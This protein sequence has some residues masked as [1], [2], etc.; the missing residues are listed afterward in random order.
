MYYLFLLLNFENFDCVSGLT[1][2]VI[3]Q[4]SFDYVRHCELII[5]LTRANKAVILCW[6]QKKL[7][8]GSSRFG[9]II[10]RTHKFGK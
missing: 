8:L 6:A 1:Q 7:L 9:V 3:F 2:N 5:H 4:I 10:S